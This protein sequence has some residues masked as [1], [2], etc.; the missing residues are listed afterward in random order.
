M[1]Y[2]VRF[3]ECFMIVSFVIYDVVNRELI[4]TL[5]KIGTLAGLL[6][7]WL[8]TLN[9]SDYVVTHNK[10]KSETITVSKKN[11]TEF[12]LKSIYLDIS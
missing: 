1:Y 10:I 5:I 7:F 8:D 11:S 12:K 3:Y 9:T 4:N 6:L 2:Y